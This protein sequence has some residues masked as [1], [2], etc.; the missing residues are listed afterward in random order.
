[1]KRIKKIPFLKKFTSCVLTPLNTK[2]HSE[3]FVVTKNDEKYFV[4][5]FNNKIENSIKTLMSEANIAHPE[6]IEV[7][8]VDN[9]FYVIEKFVD[10]K[11]LDNYMYMYSDKEIYERIFVLASKYTNL[12]KKFK[13]IKTDEEQFEK[14]VQFILNIISSDNSETVIKNIKKINANSL[15]TIYFLRDYVLNNYSVLKKCPMIYSANEIFPEKIIAT[16]KQIYYIADFETPCYNQM[17]FVL[18]NAILPHDPVALPKYTAF[19]N[20]YLEGLFQFNIPETVLESFNL[21]YALKAYEISIELISKEKFNELNEFI[22][23]ISK[24][25]ANNKITYSERLTIFNVKDFPLLKDGEFSIVKGSYNNHNLVYKVKTKKQNYFLKVMYGLNKSNETLEKYRYYYSVVKACKIPAPQM[26]D[27]GI[28]KNGK[29]IYTIMELINGGQYNVVH[30]RTNFDEGVKCGKFVADIMKNLKNAPINKKFLP[31]TT[32]DSLY[33]NL[34]DMANRVYDSKFKKYMPCS[35]VRTLALANKLKK[36]FDDEPI[37]LIHG[38]IKMENV[39]DDGKN[40]YMVDNENYYYCYQI[41]N[42]RYNLAYMY[43]PGSATIKKGFV[44][45]Y[46]KEIYGGEVPKRVHNQIKFLV[47]LDMVIR[48]NTLINNEGGQNMLKVHETLVNGEFYN[49]DYLIDWL[50]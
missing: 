31:T 8:N 10:G 44:S 16:L 22:K 47:L 45:A 46:L 27:S 20:G 28:L 49:D 6:V 21:A 43:K 26:Y 33:D 34:I 17:P 39:L 35:K 23:A 13:D 50:V 2:T 5:F 4:K 1:M 41:V 12:R 30:D 37:V 25:I 15:N 14:L 3:N 7:G 38:D 18:W 29:C 36:S 48:G 24:Y 40:I 19:V 11:T 42:F 9:Q 32:I